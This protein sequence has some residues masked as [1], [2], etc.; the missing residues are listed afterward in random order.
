LGDVSQ[1]SVA[2]TC[3]S[4]EIFEKTDKRQVEIMSEEDMKNY[5]GSFSVQ[6]TEE[7][8]DASVTTK[9]MAKRIYKGY[10]DDPR[11]TGKHF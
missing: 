3:F 5:F 10:R 1:F 4:D 6:S 7:H 2:C 9:F 11:N 8:K